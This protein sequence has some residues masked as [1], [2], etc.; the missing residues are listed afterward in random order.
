L[1]IW[2]KILSNGNVLFSKKLLYVILSVVLFCQGLPRFSQIFHVL[3]SGFLFT[4]NQHKWNNA[5]LFLNEN[6]YYP[7]SDSFWLL[8]LLTAMPFLFFP[9]EV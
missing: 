2:G 6:Q 3:F 8:K 1:Q 4:K 7:F 9:L 5:T